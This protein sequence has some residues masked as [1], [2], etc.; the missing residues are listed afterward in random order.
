MNELIKKGQHR[1]SG[2]GVPQSAL[3]P[4]CWAGCGVVSSRFR[5][6]SAVSNV[7]GTEGGGWDRAKSNSVNVNTLFQ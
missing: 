3:K 2:P 5:D 4:D 6:V 7:S 1:G